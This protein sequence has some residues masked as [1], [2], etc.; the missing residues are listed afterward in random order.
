MAWTVLFALGFALWGAC[1]AVMAVTRRL[2]GLD[3]ALRVHLAAAPSVSF[4]VSAIHALIDPG[5]SPVLRAVAFTG[6]V[7]ALDALIVAPLLERNFAMFRSLIGTWM[8]FALIFLASWAA[9]ILTP[10]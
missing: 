4:F 5:L 10:S 9:G 3:I 1:G 6:Q 8:P 2:W 7:V